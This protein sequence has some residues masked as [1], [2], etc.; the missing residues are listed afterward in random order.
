MTFYPD[1]LEEEE[2][3]SIKLTKNH[4]TQNFTQSPQILDQDSMKSSYGSALD[5]HSDVKLQG[6]QQT[7]R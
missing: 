4:K 1:Q 5:T 7:A 6:S 2:N 3:E